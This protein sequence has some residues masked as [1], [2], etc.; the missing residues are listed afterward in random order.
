[1]GG[2]LVPMF[3]FKAQHPF[4]PSFFRTTPTTEDGRSKEY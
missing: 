2:L 3:G 1:M 4:V